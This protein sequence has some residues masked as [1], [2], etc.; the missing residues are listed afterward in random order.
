MI[1]FYMDENIFNSSFSRGSTDDMNFKFCPIF[2]P[3]LSN[4]KK[5]NKIKHITIEVVF[6]YLYF[7][8]NQSTQKIYRKK[9]IFYYL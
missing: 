4:F 3:K 9:I 5:I 6:S 7:L 8:T 1:L 2:F